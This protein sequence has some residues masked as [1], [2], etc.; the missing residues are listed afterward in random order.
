[1]I[2]FISYER[3]LMVSLGYI[4]TI[5]IEI[6]LPFGLA[7]WFTRRFKTSWGLFGVGVL[8]F[9]GSQILHIPLTSFVLNPWIGSLQAKLPFGLWAA[10]AA[11]VLGLAAGI[12]EESARWI[13][14]RILKSRAKTFG[15]ALTVGAG[16]GGIESILIGIIILVNYVIILIF[17]NGWGPGLGISQQTLQSWAPQVYSM[18]NV[19]WYAELIS[20][21]ERIFAI[22]LHLGLSVMVWQ[23]VMKRSWGWFVAAVLWHAFVDAIAV[24]MSILGFSIWL[25]EAAVALTAIANVVFLIWYGKQQLEIEAE[26]EE[27]EELVEGE[28][29]EVVE[30]PKAEL[31]E[32]APAEETPLAEAKPKAKR[33]PKAPKSDEESK[34]E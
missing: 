13:G 33:K 3:S 32:E 14:F 12:F 31:T 1:M 26:G 7:I 28:A 17:T 11:I 24:V 29:V 16:H 2:E 34:E 9:I 18:L 27:D 21:A 19:P 8:T 20:A 10:I 4:L 25:T 5:L 23:A 15:S 30:A 22:T 6:L